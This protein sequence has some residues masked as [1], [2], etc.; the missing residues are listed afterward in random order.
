MLR[1]DGWEKMFGKGKIGTLSVSRLNSIENDFEVTAA[2]HPNFSF[3]YIDLPL[4]RRLANR[5]ARLA[6][7]AWPAQLG[8]HIF[9]I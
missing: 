2:R 1:G 9:L 7:S 6:G 3:N 4:R 5:L 8:L